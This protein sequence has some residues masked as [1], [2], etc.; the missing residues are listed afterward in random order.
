VLKFSAY[1][2]ADWYLVATGGGVLVTDHLA[3]AV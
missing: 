1:G 3:D 2:G